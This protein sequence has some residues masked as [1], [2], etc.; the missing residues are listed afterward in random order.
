[1]TPTLESPTAE[2]ADS[3]S[4]TTELAAPFPYTG[5]DGTT[6]PSPGADVRGVLCSSDDA[7]R[8]Q[9]GDTACPVCGGATVDGV[10]LFSCTDCAWTGVL[11]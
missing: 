6:L 9:V 2:T 4:T 8:G 1:M 5:D 7:E 11:R 10:G 3:T